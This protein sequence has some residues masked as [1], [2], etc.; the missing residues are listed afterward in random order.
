MRNF[1]DFCTKAIR[2]EAYQ[3]YDGN[4][5]Q[6]DTLPE[7]IYFRL[8]LVVRFSP[9]NLSQSKIL[10]QTLFQQR[11]LIGKL[12]ILIDALDYKY[13]CKINNQVGSEKFTDK[14]AQK[15]VSTYAHILLM[16]MKSQLYN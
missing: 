16:V 12:S 6:H 7:I 3:I 15:T 13:E 10:I 8:L 11:I 4:S 2:R 1:Q 5:K 14:V 9:F